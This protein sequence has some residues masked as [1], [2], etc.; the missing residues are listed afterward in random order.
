MGKQLTDEFDYSVTKEGRVFVTFHGRQV[1]TV[2]GHKAMA[3]LEELEAA[4]DFGI[5]DILAKLTGNF[6]RGNERQ[7]KL[8]RK[9]K[10]H[11]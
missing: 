1:M 3:L 7:V 11:C 4:D 5:Q 8:V 10:G 9:R 6:K 2:K